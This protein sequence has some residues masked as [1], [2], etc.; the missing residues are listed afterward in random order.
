MR[1]LDKEIDAVIFD[2]DGTLFDTERL[3]TKLYQ[4]VSQQMGKQ[5]GIDVINNSIGLNYDATRMFVKKSY[6]EDF[7]FDEIS[8]IVIERKLAHIE[9]HGMPIKEGVTEVLELLKENNVPMAIA[10]STNREFTEKYLKKSE[11]KGYFNFVVCG[12]EVSK[13][14][15]EPEIFLHTVNLLQ[16]DSSKCIVLED[17]ENGIIAAHRARTIPV[18]VK[19]IKYPADEVR[20][21]AFKEYESM[22]EF[23]LDID[24]S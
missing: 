21:L 22:N 15:P 2:M 10:T 6:G 7:P 19:D 5:M 8:K 3:I 13:S 14:K 12:N 1:Y 4:E 20:K 18:L 16:I 24:F 11:L 17:S 23:M 9:N